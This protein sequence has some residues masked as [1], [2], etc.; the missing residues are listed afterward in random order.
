MSEVGDEILLSTPP[1]DARDYKL[2]FIGT[3]APADQI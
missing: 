1:D 2:V 3:R